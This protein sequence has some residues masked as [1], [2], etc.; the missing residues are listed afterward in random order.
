MKGIYCYKDIEKDN[1]IVY[2][3]KDSNIHKRV[4]DKAHR[5]PLKYDAQPF[6]KIIQNNP[7]RYMYEVLYQDEDYSNDDLNCLEIESI[8]KFNPKFNFTKGG[9]GAPVGHKYNLGRMKSEETRRKI[10]EN[11][12]GIPSFW[13][14]KTFSKQHRANMSKAQKGKVGPANSSWKNY[15]RLVKA[16]MAPNGKQQ[17]RV[18]SIGN[19][20]IKRSVDKDKLLNW[21]LKE[22][23]LEIIKVGV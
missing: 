18:S 17:Y 10:S 21:F 8:K 9:D 19:K 23:P 1:E 12:K 20:T 15:Y 16:G 7:E 6:N 13:K 2:I 11:R 4:R 22:H 14:G 5:S 3:G